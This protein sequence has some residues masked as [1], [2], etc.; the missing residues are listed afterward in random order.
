M[1]SDVISARLQVALPVNYSVHVQ[2]SVEPWKL[3]LWGGEVGKR[4][5]HK[6]TPASG[7]CFFQTGRANCSHT[8]GV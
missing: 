5:N 4:A 3:C 2:N 8:S 6:E 1:V 7:V